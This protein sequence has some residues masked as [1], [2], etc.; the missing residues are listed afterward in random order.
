[1]YCTKS[2]MDTDREK[3]HQFMCV[4]EDDPNYIENEMIINMFCQMLYYF[5]WDFDFMRDFIKENEGYRTIFSIDWKNLTGKALQRQMLMFTFTDSFIAAKPNIELMEEV[6][7]EF[8]STIRNNPKLKSIC[9]RTKQDVKFLDHVLFWLRLMSPYTSSFFSRVNMTI[10]EKSLL[11]D[12][13]FELDYRKIMENQ[14]PK[15]TICQFPEPFN[16]ILKKS[17]FRQLHLSASMAK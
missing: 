12:Y 14:L 9:L 3:F 1:M 16:M 6:G 8:L 5:D 11:D 10:E 2:C 17:C 15:T 7:D 13:Y 4:S